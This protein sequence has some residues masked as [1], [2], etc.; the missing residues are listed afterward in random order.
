MNNPDLHFNVQASLQKMCYDFIVENS[1]VTEDWESFDFDA[2]TVENDLPNK[3]LVGVGEFS[4]TE[5]D[6][7]FYG[8][9]MIMISTP[10]DDSN[11]KKL[12]P[13]TSKMFFKL[14]GGNTIQLVDG[15]NGIVGGVIKFMSGTQAMPI[16][17]TKSRPLQIFNLRFGLTI[18][19]P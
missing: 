3:G 16:A 11:L 5:E 10:Q 12:K 14:R 9:C 1:L 8:D 7:M 13:L 19:S 17:R 15:D 18:Q 4:L 2:H 6:D